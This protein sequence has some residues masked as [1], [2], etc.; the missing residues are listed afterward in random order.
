ML[1]PS[2]WLPAQP[3]TV[4]VLRPVTKVI[5]LGDKGIGVKN[6]PKVVTQLYSDGN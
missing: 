5:L 4:T 1:A 3:K 2:L 6:V